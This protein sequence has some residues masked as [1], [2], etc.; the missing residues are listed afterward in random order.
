MLVSHIYIYTEAAS[1][2]RFG[3]VRFGSEAGMHDVTSGVQCG[4]F[5]FLFHEG[6]GGGLDA[7]LVEVVWVECVL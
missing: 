7:K 5:F 3:L 6:K 1:G 2:V 4:S